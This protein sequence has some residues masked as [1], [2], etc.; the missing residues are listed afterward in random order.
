MTLKAGKPLNQ[1]V[2]PMLPQPVR[3]A[4]SPVWQD[5][6]NNVLRLYFNQLNNLANGLISVE[7]GGAVFFK[8]HA[9]YYSSVTQTALAVNTAYPVSFE[10]VFTDS[11]QLGI[12]INGGV[13]ANITVLYPG[14]YQIMALLQVYSSTSTAKE[15]T[16]W[17]R[18]DSVDIPY[19]AQRTTLAK[20]GYDQVTY[21]YNVEL[22]A[23]EV[24]SLMWATND[25]N[26]SLQSAAPSAPYPGIPSATISITHT[27]NVLLE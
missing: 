14:V 4:Y 9:V 25:L 15:I 7:S 2:A 11:T 24:V 18:R 17:L 5:Q 26:A 1:V 8:P 3:D 6:F 10:N 12:E 22:R 23:D 16:V 20:T 27:S 13:H 19:S 21:I